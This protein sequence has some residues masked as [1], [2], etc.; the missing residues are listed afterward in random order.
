M[1][2]KQEGCTG[3]IDTSNPISL[4]T[5]CGGGCCGPHATAYPC[6][7]CGRLH[8]GDGSLTYNRAGQ[9][10]FLRNNEVILED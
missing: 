4:M 1:K 2:C 10:A 5:G 7:T 6:D 3:E 8:W 9:K